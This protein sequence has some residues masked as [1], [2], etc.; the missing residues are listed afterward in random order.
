MP[1]M[2]YGEPEPAREF[3]KATD[4]PEINFAAVKKM[5]DR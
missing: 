1:D 4:Y 3:S 2:K 5:P